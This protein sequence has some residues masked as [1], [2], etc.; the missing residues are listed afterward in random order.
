M[1]KTMTKTSTEML[2]AALEAH[3]RAKVARPEDNPFKDHDLQQMGSA[4]LKSMQDRMPALNVA[5]KSAMAYEMEVA[6][7]EVEQ[8]V[9]ADNSAKRMAAAR[10]RAA[11]KVELDK[12]ADSP[13][14]PDPKRLQEAWVI[15]AH[16]LP[17]ITRVANSKRQWASRHLGDVVD[18][19]IGI[20]TERMALLL[21]KSD[22]DLEVLEQAAKEIADQTKRTNQIP[23]EML[24]K[25]EQKERKRVSKARKWL[26]QVANNRVMDTLIDVYCRS[27]NLK[28]DNIDI[29]ASVMANIN[30]PGDDPM[31]SSFKAS[32]A[33]AFLGTRFQAPDGIDGNL[34]AMAINAAITDRKLDPMVEVLLANINTD[35]SFPWT[36]MAEDVI[37]AMPDGDGFWM[38]DVMVRSTTGTNRD[39]KTWELDRARKARGDI[40]RKYVRSAFEWMPGLIVSVI[41]AFDPQ[42]IGFSASAPGG[43]RAI[44]A[45]EFELFYLGD[46]PDLRH[47][48][49]PA[50]KYA[51]AAD[52][53]QAL[54]EHIAIL[55]TGNDLV[56]SA[57][58][59]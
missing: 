57:V 50:L 41:D 48:A 28:W 51:T 2:A 30:G 15:V 58:N 47:V 23:R 25:E 31:F 3:S 39:G 6:R 35:G 59:A 5:A 22:K 36:E 20:V 9:K 13:A 24:T 17:T 45:S 56:A 19:V 37:M 43:A 14:R 34:L 7:F 33:P 40:A 42:A 53:A 21:A 38:W 4:G 54:M 18:D 44:L 12:L 32:R 8:E 29:L 10:A 1:T 11:R 27:H 49:L 52:A 26:M 46:Q 16:L 55:V